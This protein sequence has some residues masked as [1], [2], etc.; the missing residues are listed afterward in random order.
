M[1]LAPTKY[2]LWVQ[3][4]VVKIVGGDQLVSERFL[5][6][7]GNHQPGGGSRDGSITKSFAE[8]E[9]N[10]NN[11]KRKEK[12]KLA[13]VQDVAKKTSDVGTFPVVS[14]QLVAVAIEAAVTSS[15]PQGTC[16]K[17]CFHFSV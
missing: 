16:E 11:E 13:R 15:S 17:S 14:A 4:V 3:R 2:L 8:I 5:V 1:P 10:K 9:A 6:V 12:V 7:Q